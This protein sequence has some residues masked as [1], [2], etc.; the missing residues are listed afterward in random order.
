[1]CLPVF[2]VLLAQPHERGRPAA[3]FLLAGAAFTD[4]LDGYIA[5]HF[6][7]VSTLGK[8]ADP[9]VDRALVLC[10]LVGATVIGALPIWLVVVIALREGVVLAG[11]GLLFF[12]SRTTRIDVSRAG[13]AGALGMMMALPLFILAHAPFRYHEAALVVAWVAVGA[14]QVLAWAAVVQYVPKARSA[15]AAGRRATPEAGAMTP[16]GPGAR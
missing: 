4:V 13:K 5:R 9:L 2:V 11:S 12:F 16:S 3:A 10:A 14:G 7:Q 6:D 8:M 15:W 1:V